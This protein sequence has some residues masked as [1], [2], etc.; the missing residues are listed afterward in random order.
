MRNA[1]TW[2]G[3]WDDVVIPTR[4]FSRTSSVAVMGMA[5]TPDDAAATPFFS[6][7][8]FAPVFVF[9]AATFCKD[10]FLFGVLRVP[11]LVVVQCLH[12]DAV[13]CWRRRSKLSQHEA[14]RVPNR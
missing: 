8:L 14:V 2:V 6:L 9:F 3:M 11:C 4:M 10:D 13:I 12:H 5:A 1:P 7:P